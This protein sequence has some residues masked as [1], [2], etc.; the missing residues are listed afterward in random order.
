VSEFVT[1]GTYWVEI[2]L[3]QIFGSGGNDQ[4][5]QLVKSLR[6]VGL[7]APDSGRS[8]IVSEL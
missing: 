3:S 5:E 6:D 8:S 7:V 2:V 4:L 1:R